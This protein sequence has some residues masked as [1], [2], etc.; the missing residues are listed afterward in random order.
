MWISGLGSSGAESIL[1]LLNTSRKSTAPLEVASA[2]NEG[3]YFQTSPNIS[4]PITMD[5][6]A[7]NNILNYLPDTH[8]ASNEN[9]LAYSLNKQILSSTADLT[10]VQ[11]TSKNYT[12]SFSASNESTNP[13]ATPSALFLSDLKAIGDAAASGDVAAAKSDLSKAEY[14]SATNIA[15][16]TTGGDASLR[17]NAN[18]RDGLVMEGYSLSDATGQADAI[19]IGGLVGTTGDPTADKARSNE[20]SD[21]ARVLSLEAGSLDQKTAQASYAALFNVV[22][23]LLGATSTSAANKT[24]ASLDSVYGSQSISVQG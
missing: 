24:L 3:D 12:D 9:L 10:G 2:G 21:L 15:P 23:S 7:I 16:P 8:A 6:D 11:S 22:N 4:H 20:I 17:S 19:T 13:W 5:I 14:D 1:S 18:I